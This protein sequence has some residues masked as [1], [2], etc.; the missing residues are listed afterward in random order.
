MVNSGAPG[1]LLA[2]KTDKIHGQ[3]PLHY[4]YKSGNLEAALWIMQIVRKEQGFD[5]YSELLNSMD[6][7][8]TLF[9]SF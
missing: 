4:A 6:H 5:A 7:V 9:L 3:T 2:F 8:S 1:K